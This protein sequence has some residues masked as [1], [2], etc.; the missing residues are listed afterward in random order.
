M[1]M[2]LMGGPGAPEGKSKFKVVIICCIIL[3]ICSVNLA[4]VWYFGLVPESVV[5]VLGDWAAGP[6][7]K[8][9]AITTPPP[10]A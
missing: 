7:K 9:P 4:V 3:I 8:K 10:S 5:D 1:M 2:P 6:N